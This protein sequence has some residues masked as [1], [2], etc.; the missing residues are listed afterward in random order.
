MA[1]VAVTS[2]PLGKE[3]Q[4]D[5]SRVGLR[6]PNSPTGAGGAGLAEGA[7]NSLPDPA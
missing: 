5:A 3:Q 4:Q 6:V 7:A 2:T 1:E